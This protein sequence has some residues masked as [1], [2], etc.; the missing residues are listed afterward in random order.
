MQTTKLLLSISPLY[1]GAS[2]QPYLIAT[3]GL[4]PSGDMYALW[5]NEVVAR[6]KFEKMK[7]WKEAKEKDQ[8]T[9]WRIFVKIPSSVQRNLF[10]R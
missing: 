5:V 10:R 3:D 2:K 8:Q 1:R 9:R 6:F 7:Y 4:H